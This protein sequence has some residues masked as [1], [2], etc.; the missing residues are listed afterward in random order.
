MLFACGAGSINFGISESSSF[1]S[2][3]FLGFIGDAVYRRWQY[4]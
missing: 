4:W 3:N 1:M 2:N